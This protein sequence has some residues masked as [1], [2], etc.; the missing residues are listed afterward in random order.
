[1]KT[2]LPLF[3]ILGAALLH[4]ADV[5]V[6]LRA[7]RVTRGGKLVTL[8]S[9]EFGVLAHLLRRAGH[10][11]TRAELAETVWE[12]LPNTPSNVI[13]VTVYHLREK[14]DRGFSPALIQTVRGAGYLL[15]TS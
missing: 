6:D 13:E 3:L 11:V 4:A 12:D 10:V 8:S 14:I 2:L 15:Q 7:R 1:M 5:Q 9:K